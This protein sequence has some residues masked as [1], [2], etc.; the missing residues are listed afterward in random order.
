MLLVQILDCVRS[1]LSS[2]ER[3]EDNLVARYLGGPGKGRA[4]L[5]RDGVFEEPGSP[6]RRKVA[7]LFSPCSG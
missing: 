6:S 7:D 1:G 2:T 4:A 3:L 5:D